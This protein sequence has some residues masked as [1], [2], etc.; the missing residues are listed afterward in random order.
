MHSLITLVSLYL[1]TIVT[2]ILN[3]QY[4]C[5]I[6]IDMTGM[7]FLEVLHMKDMIDIMGK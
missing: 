2:L 5:C 6:K 1:K 3:I 4:M 7:S